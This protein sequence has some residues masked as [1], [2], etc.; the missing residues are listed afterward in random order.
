MA[1]VFSFCIYG[2]KPIY[3]EGMVRNLEAIARHYPT[4]ETHIFAG[5]DVPTG[6][7][8]KYESFPGVT[9]HRSN[10]TGGRLMC[11]RFFAIDLTGVEIMHV[12]DA[13]SRLT[14]RDRWCIDDFNSSFFKVYSIRDHT[15]HNREIMGG[16]WGMRRIPGFDVT[17]A[18]LEFASTCHDVDAYQSDQNFLRNFIYRKFASSFLAY[19]PSWAFPGENHRRIPLARNDIYDFCGNV[20][21]PE[22]GAELPQFTADDSLPAD[23]NQLL[24]LHKYSRDGFSLRLKDR[25]RAFLSGD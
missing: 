11:H 23:F 4:F 24:R 17:N 8:K 22:N 3:C 21:L 10:L 1:S 7:L 18:Y 5:N 14:E 19:T 20:I 16:L 2:A 25:I 13:D 6:Y 15:H 9:L 12:R